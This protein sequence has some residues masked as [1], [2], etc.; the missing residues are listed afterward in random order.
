MTVVIEQAEATTEEPYQG[1][2]GLAPQCHV[3]GDTKVPVPDFPSEV[4]LPEGP[5]FF[6]QERVFKED[7]RFRMRKFRSPHQR[8]VLHLG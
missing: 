7:L 3:L 5:V 6:R 4:P 8:T 1:K 2:R